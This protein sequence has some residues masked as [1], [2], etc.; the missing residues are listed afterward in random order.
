LRQI[1]ADRFID[2]SGDGDLAAYAGAKFTVGRESDGRVQGMT[3]VAGLSGFDTSDPE[4][5]EAGRKVAVERLR[6]MA[7]RGEAPAIGGEH[8]ASNHH[9]SRTLALC[10]GGDSLDNEDLTRATMDA[11]AKL[12]WFIKFLRDNHAGC[13]HL[14]LEQTGASLGIREGRHVEGLYRFDEADILE[15]RSFRD[16]V[17]HGFWMVDVHDPKGSGDTTWLD[18]KRH[19]EPGTSYQIPYR[20][21]V[22]S[23]YDN[24]LLAGRCASATHYGMAGLRLQ[25]HCHV[26][27][28]A[29]GVAAAMSL[30]ASV[31]P[32]DISTEQLQIH[33]RTAGVWI[34][35]KRVQAASFVGER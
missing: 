26:M 32:K 10:V 35:D 16:A 33:L 31:S 12:P 24:L 15:C 6:E 13:E 34:D 23:D 7:Q 19:L 3:L 27:G 22:Q 1:R 18:Q 8:F 29:A 21:L 2:A 28:Q 17:G 30:D 25:T 14:E 11:R 20:I 9:W 4:A 5:L